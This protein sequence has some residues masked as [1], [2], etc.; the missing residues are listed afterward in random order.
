[1][2]SHSSSNQPADTNLCPKCKA[3][4]TVAHN[5][6]QWCPLCGEFVTPPDFRDT[7]H[8]QT[9]QSTPSIPE[10]HGGTPRCARCMQPVDVCS[11]VYDDGEW[12]CGHCI[13]SYADGA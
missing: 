13:A 8:I 1:M 6:G 9:K 10:V 5:G 12:L 2:N 4:K 7:K 3:T 11:G